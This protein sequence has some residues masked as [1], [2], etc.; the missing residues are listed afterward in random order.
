MKFYINQ[1][2][3]KLLKYFFAM[4]PPLKSVKMLPDAR[5]VDFGN[6]LYHLLEGIHLDLDLVQVK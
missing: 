3:N 1:R 2:V 6:I 4:L 5:I